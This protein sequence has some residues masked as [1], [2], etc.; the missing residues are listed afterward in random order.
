MQSKNNWKFREKKDLYSRIKTG[1]LRGIYSECA[2]NIFSDL[3]LDYKRVLDCLENPQKYAEENIS[4]PQLL[5]EGSRREIKYSGRRIRTERTEIILPLPEDLKK[6][7]N[8]D[9]LSLDTGVILDKEK[10]EEVKIV[11]D[12]DDYYLEVK[13]QN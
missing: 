5:P 10:I 9:N 12:R 8:I 4:V 1:K 3:I 7:Y 2:D 6:Q 11:P 13:L